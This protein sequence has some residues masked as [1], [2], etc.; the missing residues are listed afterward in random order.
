MSGQAQIGGADR[1]A[2]PAPECDRAPKIGAA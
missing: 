1:V 2:K